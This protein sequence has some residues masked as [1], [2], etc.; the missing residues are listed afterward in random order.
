[1]ETTLPKGLSY[2]QNVAEARIRRN[3]SV[4]LKTLA[5]TFFGGAFERLAV[6]ADQLVVEAKVLE[7]RAAKQLRFE[8]QFYHL[9]KNKQTISRTSTELTKL[10][11]GWGTLPK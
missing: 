7:R 11:R 10:I 8:P 2:A 3:R 9:L 5:D 4:Y 1:M 6:I